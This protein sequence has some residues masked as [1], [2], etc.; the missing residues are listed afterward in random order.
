MGW[1]SHMALVVKNPPAN[2]DRLKRHRFDPWVRKICWR[3]ATHSS[4]LAWRIPQ[5]ED[6]GGLVCGVTQ[7]QTRP[8]RLS[9]HASMGNGVALRTTDSHSSPNFPA[10]S[11]LCQSVC[12]SHVPQPRSADC[13]RIPANSQV[14]DLCFCLSPSSV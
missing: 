7:S 2:A 14:S 6:P 1:A 11:L 12:E 8:K 3:T 4:L 9:T 5:R 13:Q 10:V